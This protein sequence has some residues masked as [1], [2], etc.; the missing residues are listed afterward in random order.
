[1]K[2]LVYRNSSAS[3]KGGQRGVVKK[4]FKNADILFSMTH[5]ILIFTTTLGGEGVG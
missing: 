4:S 1:M 5:F 2:E 3:K